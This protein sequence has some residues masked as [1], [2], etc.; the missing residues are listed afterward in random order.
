MGEIRFCTL[1]AWLGPL[2]W[3]GNG[4][5]GCQ[6]L[7]PTLAR[8]FEDVATVGYPEAS[9]AALPRVGGVVNVGTMAFTQSNHHP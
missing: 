3:L 2:G 1:G 8:V 7:A 6:P 4:G 9:L 5:G